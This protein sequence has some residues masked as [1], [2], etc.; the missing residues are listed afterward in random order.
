M[1][2]LR[3]SMFQ[4]I[5][6]LENSDK[7]LMFFSY[8]WKTIK[9]KRRKDVPILYLL[10]HEARRKNRNSLQLINYMRLSPILVMMLKNV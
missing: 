2:I 5:R 7:P 9:Y 1:G 4:C 6:M 8:K 3:Y 10:K